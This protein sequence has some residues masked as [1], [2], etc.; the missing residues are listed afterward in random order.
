MSKGEITIYETQDGE[1]SIDVRMEEDTVWL[2]QEQIASL[3][4]TKRPAIT[5]HLANIYKSRELEENSTCSILEHVRGNKQLY[6]TKFY[7]LDA[8][9]SVG[10]WVDFHCHTQFNT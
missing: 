8:I 5:N 3:F 1:T 7:N 6:K 9:L 2:T 4:E 10:Y